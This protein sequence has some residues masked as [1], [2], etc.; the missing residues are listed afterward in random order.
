MSWE[1]DPP[2]RPDGCPGPSH[3]H[4][5]SRCRN[6]RAVKVTRI[7]G[8]QFRARTHMYMGDLLSV[9]RLRSDSK[10]LILD[11][12]KPHIHV[13]AERPEPFGISLFFF[14]SFLLV[15]RTFS[16]D[17]EGKCSEENVGICVSEPE[18]ARCPGRAFRLWFLP[19]RCYAVAEP[20]GRALRVVAAVQPFALWL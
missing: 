16:T 13:S 17:K 9:Q 20:S 18:S 2:V 5:P 3:E 10:A 6:V 19:G 15:L 1:P 11:A 8:I 12:R 7:V 4:R 14:P